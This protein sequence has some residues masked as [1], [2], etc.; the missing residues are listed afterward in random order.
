[1]VN[2]VKIAIFSSPRTKSSF[3]IDEISKQFDIINLHETWTGSNITILKVPLPNIWESYK[4]KV[5]KQTNTFFEKHNDFGFAWKAW[6]GSFCHLGALITEKE[7][8]FKN[9]NPK[10]ILDLTKHFRY[11]EFTEFYLLQRDPTERICSWIHSYKIKKFE[12]E[13]NEE[14]KQY[15]PFNKDTE[16]YKTFLEINDFFISFIVSDLILDR[17]EPYLKTLGKPYTKL[18]FNEVPNHMKERFNVERDFIPTN[19]SYRDLVPE[20][21]LIHKW[22]QEQRAIYEPYTKQLN[23][24]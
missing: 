9:G 11:D 8:F 10:I 6:P 12:Y 4:K 22:V 24:Y 2:S 14:V 17:L 3:V 23:F 20:Y 18:D 7:N 16:I 13:N 15:H 19:Y 1:M 21:E 5:T